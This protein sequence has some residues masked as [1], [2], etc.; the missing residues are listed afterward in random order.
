MTIAYRPKLGKASARRRLVRKKLMTPPAPL[1][2][3]LSTSSLAIVALALTAALA[4]CG[5]K[6]EK[7]PSQ[8]AAKVNK[9]E[10]TVHQINF[11]LQQQRGLRPEQTDAASR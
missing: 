5:D 11:V 2:L 7:S 6:K 10:I 4:G 8:T 3:R 9:E 1:P